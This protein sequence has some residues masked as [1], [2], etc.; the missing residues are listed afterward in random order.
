[1]KDQFN[2]QAAS[3]SA[4]A[5]GHFTM[6]GMWS[7]THSP[8]PKRPMSM[9]TTGIGGTGL[10]GVSSSANCALFSVACNDKLFCYFLNMCGYIIY[11][12]THYFAVIY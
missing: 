6:Q 7:P 10:A 12:V 9:H 8:G 3:M 2:A 11:C 1:M 5:G 4:T